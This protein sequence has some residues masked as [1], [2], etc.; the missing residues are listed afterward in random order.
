MDEGISNGNDS[1]DGDGDN[2]EDESGDDDD[3]DVD[4]DNDVDGDDHGDESPP[5]NMLWQCAAPLY[6][7]CP[8][9]YELTMATMAPLEL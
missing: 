5:M 7:Y 9:T 1:L 3:D 4:D 6:G 8:L 2:E